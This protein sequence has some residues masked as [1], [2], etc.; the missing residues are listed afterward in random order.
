[1]DAAEKTKGFFR[2]VSVEVRKVSWPTWKE[3]Q[4]STVLVI[5][6]VFIIMIF[7]GIIDRA[8]SWAVESLLR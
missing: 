2:E 6:T 8:F 3:L 1:M 7:V 4:E 5:I